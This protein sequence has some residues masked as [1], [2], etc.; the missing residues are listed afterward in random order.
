MNQLITE[1]INNGYKNNLCLNEE[2]EKNDTY[3]IMHIVKEKM[4]CHRHKLIGSPLNK[5]EM[6]ALILYTGYEANYDLCKSQREGNYSKWKWFDYCL[7]HGIEK[8][9]KVEIGKFNVYT[10][11]SSVQLNE[12]SVDNGYFVTYV[13]AS[14]IKDVSLQFA[15]GKG[16]IIEI[17][18]KYKTAN[19]IKCCDVSWI[20]KFPDECEILFARSLYYYQRFNCQV[21][22]QKD[23]IQTVFL[24]S[25]K[26]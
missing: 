5:A 4:E 25:N 18:S 9:S 22:D 3:S 14:W 15:A 2:D 21:I 1:V 24:E 11:L 23:Q 6:L 19:D 10:G 7:Y 12:K 26:K 20:S 16:M 13:S 8:L 17:D